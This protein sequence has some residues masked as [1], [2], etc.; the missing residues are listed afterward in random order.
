MMPEFAVG[1]DVGGGH[2]SACVVEVATGTPI[3]KSYSHSPIDSKASQFEILNRWANVIKASIDN[4]GVKVKNVGFAMPGPFDY[5]TGIAMFENTDKYES[6]FGVNISTQL[7]RLLGREFDFR[8]WND[9]ASFGAGEAWQ[10]KAK[11]FE[12]AT[13]ISLGT[14][15]GSTFLD[16]GLPVFRGADV[17]PHGCVWHLHYKQGIADDYFSTRWL[18]SEFNR[19][20]SHNIKGVLEIVTLKSDAGIQL[21]QQFGT[22]LGKFLAPWLRK[23]GTEVLIF[24]GSISKSIEWFKAPLQAELTERELDVRLEVSDLG[25]MAAILGGV[26]LFDPKVWAKVKPLL[27]AI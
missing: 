26:R 9:A 12:K 21:L 24:G 25:E 2:I 5:Q 7:G 13:I 27:P 6:L 3:T 19:R 1:V 11:C 15:I 18:V 4:S 16:H 8:Y 14:G 10:G 23:F 17:P 20:T 22:E